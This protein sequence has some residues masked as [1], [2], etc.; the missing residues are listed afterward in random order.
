MTVCIKHILRVSSSSL[1]R[2][3]QNSF[4]F[5]KLTKILF[6]K[7]HALNSHKS[8]VWGV[9]EIRS[10]ACSRF[11]AIQCS[12]SHK[13]K[14]SRV[15]QRVLYGAL[16]WHSWE[17]SL[18]VFDL[19]CKSLYFF[20]LCRCYIILYYIWLCVHKQTKTL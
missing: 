14:K 10:Q 7:H 8:L 1:S 15:I 20:L 16:W 11:L 12:S 5:L 2:Y 18:N 19:Y 4:E 17:I 13:L 3:N 9:P 6:Y